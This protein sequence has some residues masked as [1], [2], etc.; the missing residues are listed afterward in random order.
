MAFR[1]SDYLNTDGTPKAGVN[2]MQPHTDAGSTRF[3]YDAQ[4]IFEQYQQGLDYTAPDALDQ[5]Y[6]RMR[7]GGVNV[8]RKG[9]LFRIPGT[10][11]GWVDILQNKAAV[12]GR[13][14]VRGWAYQP[15]YGSEDFDRLVAMGRNPHTGDMALPGQQFSRDQDAPIAGPGAMAP[16]GVPPGYQFNPNP[17]GI[18][19]AGGPGLAAPWMREF[20]RPDPTQIANDPSFQFQMDQ[21]LQAIERSA[22]A[23]GTLRGGGTL[24][25]LTNYAQGLAST[26]DDKY[27]NRAI[28]EYGMDRDS[29]F[30]NKNSLFGQLN[31][32]SSL[33]ANAAA[34]TGNFAQ[35]YG[36]TA[37]GLISGQGNANA[38]A[39]IARGNAWSGLTNNLGNVGL[40]AYYA[41]LY[42]QPGRQS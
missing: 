32:L 22:A 38:A 4:P 34:Q 29:F 40:Q 30:Q 42:N 9:D 12:E 21:G 20:Q 39:D 37:S 2:L 11:A 23:R 36:N 28:G 16:G 41:N 24:K 31:N 1:F 7:A 19:S 14:P 15:F 17:N 27:Y 5:L 13:G 33:G 6:A 35:G 18:W 8:E 26:F 3:G 25:D 10:D